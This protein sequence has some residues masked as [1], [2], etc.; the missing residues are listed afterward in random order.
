MD[1]TLV[2]TSLYPA[3]LSTLATKALEYMDTRTENAWTTDYGLSRLDVYVS[4]QL[5]SEYF[6]FQNLFQGKSKKSN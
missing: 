5:E 2:L 3:T 4:I 6:F 1:T